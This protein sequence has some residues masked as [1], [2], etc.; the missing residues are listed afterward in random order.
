MIS[1][2]GATDTRESYGW[3]TVECAPGPQVLPGKGYFGRVT[4]PVHHDGSQESDDR[5]AFLVVACG[6]HRHDADVWPRSAPASARCS[7]AGSARTRASSFPKRGPT[8]TSRP[9][10]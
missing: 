8:R 2:D 5:L 1:Y 10:R 7:G 4:P 6:F 9:P 3:M